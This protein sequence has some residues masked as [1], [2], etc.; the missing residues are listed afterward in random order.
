MCDDWNFNFN[1]EN[2]LQV[3]KVKIII[4]NN[5]VYTIIDIALMNLF[6]DFSFVIHKFKP[7]VCD[8]KYCN[9]SKKTPDIWKEITI[10]IKDISLC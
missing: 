3:I 7:Y 4:H 10:R 6:Y 8:C 9:K 5:E 2:N 1:S